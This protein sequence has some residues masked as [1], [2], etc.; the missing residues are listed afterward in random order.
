MYIN[1]YTKRNLC[2]LKRILK[3]NIKIVHNVRENEIS[4]RF[5]FFETELKQCDN[6]LRKLAT[7]SA[8]DYF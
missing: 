3:Q 1:I 7:S 5:S 2:H 6:Y 4:T 8:E